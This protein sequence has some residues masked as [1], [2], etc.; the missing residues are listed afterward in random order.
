MGFQSTDFMFLLTQLS[1]NAIYKHRTTFLLW[2]SYQAKEA[3]MQEVTRE[4][5]ESIGLSLSPRYREGINEGGVNISVDYPYDD[6]AQVRLGN[7]RKNA[8]K[9]KIAWRSEEA[10]KET[11]ISMIPVE[12]M[13]KFIVP[14]GVEYVQIMFCDA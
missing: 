8:I 1:K 14:P 12:C 7:H 4:G 10:S 6:Q 9:A 2:L 13:S 11:A 5:W 3:H